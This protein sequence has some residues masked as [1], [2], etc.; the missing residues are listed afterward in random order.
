M[1]AALAEAFVAHRRGQADHRADCLIS[2]RAIV[3]RTEDRV[4]EAIVALAAAT[5]DPMVREVADDRLRELGIDAHG[6]V[7][8]LQAMRG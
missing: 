4:H 5:L 2:A 7:T 1:F 3:A 6:W 8:L